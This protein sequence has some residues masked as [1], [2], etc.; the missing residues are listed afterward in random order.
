MNE[1]K[2][3]RYHRLRRRASALSLGAGTALLVGLA[4]SG[5]SLALRD[6]AARLGGGLGPWGTVGVYV[7][8]L[9]ALHELA[10]LPV[11]FYRGHV[12]DWRYGLSRETPRRWL[13]D[14][15]RALA[16][17]LV[18]GLLAAE[19]AYLLLRRTPDTW[20]IWAALVF[21]AATV[22]LTQLAPVLLLPIF[23]R[24]TP[25]ARDGLRARLAT[26]AARAGVPVLGV[27]EWHLGERSRRANA[28]L[29]GL[30]WTRRVLLSDTLLAEYADDEIEAVLA[31]E[32][33]HQVHGDIWKALGVEGGLILAGLV[34]ADGLL[35]AFGPVTGLNGPDDVAGLPL[36]LLG[37]GL[38]S[39]VLMPF[40]Y[41]LSRRHERR[42]DRFALDLT[43][44]PAAFVA[45]MRRLASQNLAEESP[46]RLVSVLLHSHPSVGE[47]VAAAAAFAARQGEEPA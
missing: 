38:A 8:A 34:T 42:A 24:V 4:A 44:R 14:H 18:F 40:A 37:S 30:G 35:R 21:W 19:I 33:G 3:A 27:Y 10:T 25:L 22:G 7:L 12:L 39:L 41:A 47:R 31:H 29:V 13:R 20:W 2:S 36:L 23:Y 28:A 17:G 16:V 45:A 15:V 1:D 6:L 9:A 32:L 43:G 11:S 46:S 5:A 26:L